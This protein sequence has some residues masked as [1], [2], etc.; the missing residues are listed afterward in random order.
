MNPTQ[1]S[2]EVLQEIVLTNRFESLHFAVVL[3]SGMGGLPTIPEIVPHVVNESTL[4]TMLSLHNL[5]HGV[6]DQ[7]LLWRKLVPDVHRSFLALESSTPVRPDRKPRRLQRLVLDVE[8]GGILYAPIGDCGW[9]FAATLN[10]QAMNDG[11]AEQDL[12]RMV[13]KLGDVLLPP[14][15]ALREKP[16]E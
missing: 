6:S 3:P 12:I 7:V 8:V 13:N 11:S 5:R 4:A 14:A 10:Q 2:Q 9:V 1:A 15:T 16:D